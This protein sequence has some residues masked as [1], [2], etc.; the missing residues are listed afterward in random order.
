MHRFFK[1]KLLLGGIIIGFLAGGSWLAWSAIQYEVGLNTFDT[2]TV[3]NFRWKRVIGANA[4]RNFV[5]GSASNQGIPAFVK[6]TMNSLGDINSECTGQTLECSSNK[7][8]LA[9]IGVAPQAAM[10]SFKPVVSGVRVSLSPSDP[11]DGPPAFGF[12]Y[13]G[14]NSSDVYGN[15]QLADS[16]RGISATNLTDTTSVGT[17]MNVPLSTWSVTNTPAAATK[18]T[19]SKAAGGGTVRH[20]ATSISVCTAQAGTAQTPIAINLRD[21][22]TGAGTVLRTWK[23]SSI[24]Q[25]SKCVESS[26]L[27]M[28]GT[29]NTAMTIEFG[30]AGVAASEQTVTLTGFSVP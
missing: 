24:I 18:A 28:I 4:L 26:G 11:V 3:G 14:T 10:T 25:D 7:V 15:F 1:S 5:A 22:A 2:D 6:A 29:A 30:A 19:A 13:R 8:V 27:A 9:P 12:L 20:V 21:G 16:I 17:S 23:M